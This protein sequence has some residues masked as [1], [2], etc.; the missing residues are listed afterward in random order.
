MILDH[1]DEPVV[2][3]HGA[4]STLGAAAARELADRGARLALAA[5]SGGDVD[6]L[7]SDLTADGAEAHAVSAAS[8]RTNGTS[9]A[10]AVVDATV[11]AYDGLD[12]LVN[13]CTPDPES[14]EA[15]TQYGAQLLDRCRAAGHAMTTDATLGDADHT[16]IV[17]HCFMP[18]LF[19]DTA[20]D[21]PQLILQ[22]TV[23]ATTE[24]VCV[25]F[26][27]QGVRANTILTGL[28][29]VPELEDAIPDAVRNE[30]VPIQRW[31]EPEDFAKAVAYL[32]LENEYVTGQDIF[33]DGGLTA[34][35]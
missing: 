17:N 7:V 16:S 19:A 1:T 13:V 22:D 9:P 6:A 11:D 33:L 34:T 29:D 5:A 32:T 8:A 25:E 2:L 18:S 20:L 23:H 3:I 24:A 31:G 26:G 35:R 14:P 21:T 27:R 30:E 10:Q 12:A 15:H 28:F 4:D